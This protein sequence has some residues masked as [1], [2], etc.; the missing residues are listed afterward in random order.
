MQMKR[1]LAVLTEKNK[2]CEELINK[3]SSALNQRTQ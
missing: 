1:E 3:L 2:V